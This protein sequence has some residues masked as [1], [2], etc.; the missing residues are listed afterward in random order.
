MLTNNG[1]R[2]RK[3]RSSHIYALKFGMALLSDEDQQIC[4][5]VAC[6][7]RLHDY[8]KSVYHGGKREHKDSH[9]YYPEHGDPAPCLTE[10]RLAILLEEPDFTLDIF[11]HAFEQWK[12]VEEFAGISPTSAQ[13]VGY[14][15]KGFD[16]N[17]EM[18]LLTGS[19]EYL[20]A[21]ALLSAM[22][23]FLRFGTFN[24]RF[25][26][27]D[28][29]SVESSLKEIFDYEGAWKLKDSNHMRTAGQLIPY[30]LRNRQ[31]L[32]EGLGIEELY[33]LGTG[34]LFHSQSGIVALCQ[35][36]GLNE[37][38]ASRVSEFRKTVEQYTDQLLDTSAI[39]VNFRLTM[40]GLKRRIPCES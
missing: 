37:T 34:F 9:A 23:L 4:K 22:T 14:E 39:N 28:P 11:E 3:P 12:K 27:D 32:F 33:P 7:D 21:P 2:I 5:F 25:T 31:E 30:I 40:I 10:L 18:V 17:K 24:S 29:S 19:S 16:R 36:I 35:G 38:L 1:K 8:L 15:K 26:L 13:L 20:K 6:R